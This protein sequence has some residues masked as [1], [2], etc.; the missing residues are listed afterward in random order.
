MRAAHQD[1]PR[2]EMHS[3]WV[4]SAPHLAEAALCRCLRPPLLAVA[5]AQQPHDA[6][7]YDKQSPAAAHRR[8]PPT[9]LG[10]RYR[11]WF[12]GAGRAPAKEV[13]ARPAPRPALRLPRSRLPCGRAA[14]RA[15]AHA[16][17]RRPPSSTPR[18]RTRLRYTWPAA[19]P[20]QRR[21]LPGS[22][23]PRASYTARGL[24][25][26]ACPAPELTPALPFLTTLSL[27]YV[28]AV[29][30]PAKPKGC[31]NSSRGAR[32]HTRFSG[33]LV[34]SFLLPTKGTGEI[35]FQRAGR[36]GLHL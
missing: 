12:P 16:S 9:A 25:R 6:Q 7:E 18:S 23:Y 11:A 3:P 35:D 22:G 34:L 36:R 13:W 15:S 14:A 21:S 4:A 27:G 24:R 32:P 30:W 20:A 1:R 5:R 19:R 2:P 28:S 26:P 29:L 10:P 17:L 31:W 33:F 8:S